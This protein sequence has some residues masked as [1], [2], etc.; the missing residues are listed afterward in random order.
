MLGVDVCRAVVGVDELGY[1]AVDCM[2]CEQD[3]LEAKRGLD[4]RKDGRFGC[5]ERGLH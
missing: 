3:S 1:G 2:N 5:P 4:Y